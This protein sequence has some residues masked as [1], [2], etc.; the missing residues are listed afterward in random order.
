MNIVLTTVLAI[1]TALM[2]YVLWYSRFLFGR[3]SERLRRMSYVATPVAVSKKQLFIAGCGLLVMAYTFA[4]FD[5]RLQPSGFLEGFRLGAWLWLGFIA[6]TQLIDGSAGGRPFA[7]V[8]INSAYYL[9]VLT[10]IGGI[11]AIV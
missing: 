7:L 3:R 9:V 11:L 5:Q 4:F 2:V 8:A 1:A 10:L 6:T